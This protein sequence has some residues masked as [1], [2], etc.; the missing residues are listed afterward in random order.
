M[1]FV[2][3]FTLTFLLTQ[4]WSY[5]APD[6]DA[7]L[8]QKVEILERKLALLKQQ[9]HKERKDHPFEGH[10]SP[11]KASP[12]GE[13]VKQ[14]AVVR[15]KQPEAKIKDAGDFSR[16]QELY[17]QAQIFLNQKNLSKAK[18]V[19]QELCDKYSDAPQFM[20]ARYW[21][22]EIGME[23]KDYTN[24]S[25]A[26][27]EAYSAYKQKLADKEAIS[28]EVHYRAIESLAKLAYCLKWLKKGQDAC[29]TLKQ[30]EKESAGI[31][32]NIQTFALQV[33]EQLKCQKKPV[34]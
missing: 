27:G 15:T 11:L 7:E 1:R 2:Q 10:E 4:V 8:R 21:L 5:A 13:N 14:D 17:S 22:G 30:F 29:V 31:P 3:I 32:R 19:L 26:Y 9:T 25:I 24:A 6:V 28:D 23:G 34:R 18:V 16:A 12:K 33:S 20:L